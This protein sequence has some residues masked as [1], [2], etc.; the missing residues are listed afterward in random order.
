MKARR[1]RDVKMVGQWKKNTHLKIWIKRHQTQSVF[2]KPNMNSCVY[3]ICLEKQGV[4]SLQS[5]S[6]SICF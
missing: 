4:L 6:F 2:P 3:V 1:T 5:R